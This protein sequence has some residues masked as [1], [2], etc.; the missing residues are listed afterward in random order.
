AAALAWGLARCWRAAGWAAAAL[1]LGG[2]GSLLSPNGLAL[3]RGPFATVSNDYLA[4]NHDWVS[5]KPFSVESAA[6]GL[7]LLGAVCLGVWRRADPRALA[8]VGLVLPSIQL[9][10]FSPF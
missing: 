2:G 8:A 10:R 1:A 9:A 4:Y 3:W 5:L 6:V 7:L